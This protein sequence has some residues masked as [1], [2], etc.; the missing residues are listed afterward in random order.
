MDAAI[1][2]ELFDGD[3]G[4][5]PDFRFGQVADWEKSLAQLVLCQLAKEIA[6]VLVGVDTLEYPP[7]RL[8]VNHDLC[9]RIIQQGSPA[10]VVP[11]CH[12]VGPQ[13]AGGLEEGIELDLAVAQ[14]IGIRSP[15]GRILIEH[16][17]HHSLAVLLRQVHEIERDADLPGNEFGDEAVLLPLTVPVEGGIGIVPVL[18][19]HG[20]DIIALLLEQ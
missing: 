4:D 8:A 5:F 10:A 14:D 15:A 11:G 20:E 6:L 18:H 3:A 13:A 16:V 9:P 17:I 19:E 12:H 1:H 2:D 7:L